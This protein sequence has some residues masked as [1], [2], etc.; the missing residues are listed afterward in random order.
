MSFTQYN[1]KKATI[2]STDAQCI[3]ERVIHKRGAD[4]SLGARF[5]LKDDQGKEHEM[6]PHEIIIEE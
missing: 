5:I 1:G 2:K 4:G 6:M 3:I